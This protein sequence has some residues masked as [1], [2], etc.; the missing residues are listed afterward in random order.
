MTVIQRRHY[1]ATGGNSGTLPTLRPGVGVAGAVH[2]WSAS[3]LTANAGTN[4]ESWADII[5]SAHLTQPTAAK[6][7]IIGTGPDGFKVV[8]TD[9]VDDVLTAGGGLPDAKTITLLLR[10]IDPAGTTRAL[11]GWDGGYLRRGSTGTTAS[12]RIGAPSANIAADVTQ[13]LFHT[14]TVINDFAGAKGATVVDGTYTA[15]ATDRENG[16]LLIGNVA[17][18]TY[19]AIEVLDAA[20]YGRALTEAECQTVRTAYQKA[21]PG[22]VA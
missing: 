17:G 6:Q 20:A 4:V 1:T 2:R 13:P 3:T 9:G 8:R 14:V 22:L 18:S 19:G 5:G 16:N 12:T 15:Q 11:I 21:F 10:S 7:P